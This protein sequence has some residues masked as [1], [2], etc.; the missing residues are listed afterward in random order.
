[1]NLVTSLAEWTTK[2]IEIPTNLSFEFSLLVIP[3]FQ[4]LLA[5]SLLTLGPLWTFVSDHKLPTQVSFVV[6][7]VSLGGMLRIG[8]RL[9]FLRT[10][11]RCCKF[12]DCVEFVNVV[13]YFI[14]LV[15]CY[16]ILFSFAPWHFLFGFIVFVLH[17][18]YVQLQCFCWL[19]HVFVLFYIFVWYLIPI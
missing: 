16:L 14:C 9:L 10:F 5:M 17:V 13:Q 7:W 2:F 19:I 6:G 15:Y 8:F 18:K 11:D 3:T 1:M 4:L 12:R